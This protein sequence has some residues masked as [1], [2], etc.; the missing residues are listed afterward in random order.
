M[1]AHTSCRKFTPTLSSEKKKVKE[2]FIHNSIKA[3]RM[4]GE[5][6]VSL[7]ITMLQFPRAIITRKCHKQQRFNLLV[8]EAKVPKQARSLSHT[9]LSWG[10]DPFWFILVAIAHGNLGLAA[11]WLL[12]CHLG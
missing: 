3:D 9:P 4:I 1:V 11:A 7:E 6:L 10:L 12:C 8:L 2:I 5:N